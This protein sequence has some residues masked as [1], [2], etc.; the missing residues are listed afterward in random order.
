MDTHSIVPPS[1]ILALDGDE[2]SASCPE[3]FTP[4]EKAPGTH[5]IEGWVGLRACMDTMQT[6]SKALVHKRTIPTERSPLIGQTSANF[7]GCWMLCGHHN[8]SLRLYS[9]FSRPKP[10]L[11]LTSSS[12]IVLTSWV[13][14][15]PDP[16][17]LRKSGS[18]GN[19][20]RDLWI[21]SQELW[22]LDHRGGCLDTMTQ[23]KHL[24]PDRNL[25]SGHPGH[26]LVLNWLSYHNTVILSI[27][28]IWKYKW[29]LSSFVNIPSCTPLKLHAR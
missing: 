5:W 22:P 7:W 18:I 19:W 13:D 26:N 12:S 4:G 29:Y 23:R 17:L 2:L 3:S 24:V 16:L 6:N 28:L 14:P 27:I 10:L 15:V 1:L 21:C 9:H 11:F 25:I 8:E 20:T